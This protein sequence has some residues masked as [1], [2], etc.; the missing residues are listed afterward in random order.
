MAANRFRPELERGNGRGATLTFKR[1]E[2]AITR[3]EFVQL[4][5]AGVAANLVAGAPGREA[6]P[7]AVPLPLKVVAFDAFPIFSPAPVGARAEALFPGQG[8]ALGEEW[9]L[10]QFEYAWL[11]LLSR[12]Y[13]DFWT[14]TQ[15]ALVFAARKLRLE[16][17][18]DKRDSLMSAFLDLAPWPDVTPA[19]DALAQSGLRLAFLSNLTPRM[20]ESNLERSRLRARFDRVLST[21]QARTYKPD[22]RAYELGTE[23]F[24]L[25]R[26]EILFVAHAGWDAAGAK[27]FG[28]PTFWVNRAGLPP[29]ELGVSP[30]ATGHDLSKLVEFVDGFGAGARRLR[31]GDGMGEGSW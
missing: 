3:R 13:V 9:R 15:D 25:R 7:A 18:A 8:A 27:S 30:D 19:L 21:D 28:Y 29:E 11:R 24:G 20:L 2:M 1:I 12:R 10:R 22:P 26:E 5:T 31:S 14:V 17:D 23:V 6:M 16:L 4:T